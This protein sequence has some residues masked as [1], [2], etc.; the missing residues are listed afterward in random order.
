[1]QMRIAVCDDEK[2]IFSELNTLFNEY[3]KLTSEIISATHFSSGRDLLASSIQFD[4]VFMDYQMDGL[5]GMETSRVL[6]SCDS[7]VT[8]IFLTSFPQ[9]VF[10]SFEVNTFRFLVKPIQKQELFNA[11]NA[12]IKSVKN[13]DFLLLNTNDGTQRF[14]LSE[15]IY[16]EAQGKRCVIRTVDDHFECSKY[17]K[18]FEAMLP[19]DSFMRTHKS[20]IVHF[21]HIHNHDNTTIFFDNGERGT[22]GKRYISNFKKAFQAY[23]LPSISIY[24][25]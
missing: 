20:C 14:R 18:E 3:S 24:T 10:Q 13:D 2:I 9:V 7:N 11:L 25:F 8:I 6:R 1:M 22:I 23:I 19:A 4:L 16:I 21:L 5:D 15:I 12:Y 17:L